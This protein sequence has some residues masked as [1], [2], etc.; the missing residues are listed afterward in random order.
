MQL[1]P[2][3]CVLHARSSYP[4]SFD[5]PNNILRTAQRSTVRLPATCGY[6]SLLSSGSDETKWSPGSEGLGIIRN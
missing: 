2:F 4:P 6:S 5:H 1:C 3:L